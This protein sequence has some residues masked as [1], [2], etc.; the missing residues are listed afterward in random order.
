MAGLAMHLSKNISLLLTMKSYYCLRSPRR[1]YDIE[2]WTFF[3]SF[4]FSVGNFTKPF[5]M[6]WEK[7][8]LKITRFRSFKVKLHYAIFS[9]F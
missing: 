9:P 1:D 4:D 7:E 6:K 2:Q 5:A 8:F 3:L